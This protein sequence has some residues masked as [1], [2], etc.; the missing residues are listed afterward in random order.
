MCERA[1]VVAVLLCAGAVL[2][3]IAVAAADDGLPEF[4]DSGDVCFPHAM[5]YDDLGIECVSC[6]HET[7]AAE[8]DM[9]H[10]DYFEDLWIDC[11]ICHKPGQAASVPLAC[12]NCHHESP[13]DI[14]DQTLSSKVVIH[15]SCWECHD[16]GRAEE[17]SMACKTCHGG[18][19]RHPLE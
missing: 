16:V 7:N 2:V 5:H 8:L 13:T 17:A 10:E 4:I 19:H 6:H 15:K 3:G 18:E 11:R 14:A 12:S 9:P 1:C